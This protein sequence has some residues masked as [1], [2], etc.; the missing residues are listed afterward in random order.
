LHSDLISLFL[1]HMVVNQNVDLNLHWIDVRWKAVIYIGG[2][3][4]QICLNVGRR[5]NGLFSLVLIQK[6]LLQS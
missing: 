3:L 4:P 2:Q 5:T 1:H 6:N